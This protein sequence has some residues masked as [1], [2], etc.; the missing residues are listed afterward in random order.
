MREDGGRDVGGELNL[1]SVAVQLVFVWLWS[2]WA[3]QSPVDT[4]LHAPSWHNQQPLLR[5]QNP[6]QGCC[7]PGG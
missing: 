4:W 6:T 1:V 3:A 7:L 5:A 2:D